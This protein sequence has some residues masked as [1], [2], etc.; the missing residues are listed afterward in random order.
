[1]KRPVLESLRQVVSAVVRAFPGGRESA[2]ACIGYELKRFDNHL[3]ENAGNRPLSYDQ[4][5]QLERSIGTT[6]LPEFIANLYGGMFV[7]LADPETLDNVELYQRSVKTDAKRGVVDQI[8]A[9]ALDD[10]VIEEA[11]AK[12]I[13]QAHRR[14]LAARTAEV[15]A[16]IQL[17]RGK[18]RHRHK[19]G[20]S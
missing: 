3:Y 8:I 9:K 14:Y 16:T 10:G 20:R 15:Q 1:M 11:E 5:H 6:Y 13:M 12:E 7:P 2:A 4:I 17:H 18:K 19:G